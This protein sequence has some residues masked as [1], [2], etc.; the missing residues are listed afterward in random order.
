MLG[1][2]DE[3]QCKR[4][5]TIAA[6][7]IAASLY[8]GCGVRSGE[9][10]CSR[11]RGYSAGGMEGKEVGWAVEGGQSIHWGDGSWGREGTSGQQGKVWRSDKTANNNSSNNNTNTN[12]N[13]NKDEEVLQP[14]TIVIQSIYCPFP[15]AYY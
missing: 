10:D 8:A 9:E 2:E 4:W 3:R 12:T 14:P 7:G 11:R 1:F 15:T 13:Y 5:G 6:G